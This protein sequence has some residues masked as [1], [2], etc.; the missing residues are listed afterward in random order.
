VTPPVNL[1]PAY[2]RWFTLAI[3]LPVN[4]LFNDC[5]EALCRM[6]VCAVIKSYSKWSGFGKRRMTLFEAR[7]PQIR[8][9]VP[10]IQ[11]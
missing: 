2:P 3:N 9:A 7:H 1:D 6:Q 4:L 5:S 10:Q 8:T 11:Q